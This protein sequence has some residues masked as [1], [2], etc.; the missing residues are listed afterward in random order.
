[1]LIIAV[2]PYYIII[3]RQNKENL[4][5]MADFR[6]GTTCEE[7]G[8]AKISISPEL[9][10]EMLEGITQELPAIRPATFAAEEDP[11]TGEHSTVI[12]VESTNYAE[13]SM[14][15]VATHLT[16]NV[17]GVLCQR[18]SQQVSIQYVPTR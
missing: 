18:F 8:T 1:M 10:P 11:A 5:K 14:P 2:L 7:S 13:G 16:G 15:E 17:A 9:G 12:I 6:I 3:S 4:I